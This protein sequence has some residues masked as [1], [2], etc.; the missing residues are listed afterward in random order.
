MDGWALLDLLKHDRRTRHVP[1]HVI[2]VDDQRK[3]G[4][5]A[6]AFGYLEK[7]VD[8]DALFTA[9]TRTRDFVDRPV[10]NLIVV[11]DDEKQRASIAALIG[12][13][14]VE[15]TAVGTAAGA[16]EA[17]AQRRFDCAIID[18]G[19]PDRPGADLIEDIRQR[20]EGADLPII[21]YTG[22]D[23]LPDE[24]ERIGRQASTIIVKDVD[25]AQRLLD[26][27]A[28]FLHRAI[29]ATPG[30]DGRRDGAAILVEPAPAEVERRERPVAQAPD[31]G[32]PRDGLGGRKVL[33]VDDDM[34]NIFSLTSA[35]EQHGMAVL[36]AEGGREGLRLLEETPDLDAMLV[37]IMMPGMDGYEVM[38]AVR[39][40]PAWRSLPVIAVTAKAMKG[41]RERCLEAG[42]SDY[43][44]KPVD[45][46]QLLAVLR[47]QI[48]GGRANGT[49]H[50]TLLE[51]RA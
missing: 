21:V 26:E 30:D 40:E 14:D 45:L 31:P 24:E 47:V 22:Q 37:D 49:L 5:R 44:S 1:I 7:P 27:T 42:A 41:D 3:R 28:L 50:E 12:D 25:S 19:L 2:S 6:G 38:R 32:S 10:R 16:L 4:L 43:V 33:I 29:G 36:F 13:G 51:G 39:A 9:L 17:L 8:R 20:P 34:R 35:L 46:D 11:E 23:L 18:L 15:V 48:G